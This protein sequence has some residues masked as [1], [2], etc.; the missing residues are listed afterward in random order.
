[1]IKQIDILNFKSL[2]DFQIPCTNLNLFTGTNGAGKS[3]ALQS[4]LLLRQS[5]LSRYFYDD[6]DTIFLGDEQSLVNLG[7]YKDVFYSKAKKNSC[8]DF[9]IKFLDGKLN[10][11]TVKYSSDNKDLNSIIGKLTTGIKDLKGISLF[12][13]NFQYLAAERISPKEDYPRF[14]SN[15][16]S[17]GK[18]GSFTAHFL[19]KFGNK[20]VQIEAFAT[21][22]EIR[23]LALIDH[24]NF[25]MGRISE[26]IQVQTKENLATNRVELF[27]R[28]I[29]QDGVPG[30]DFKPSNV[31]FG[32]TH[33]LPIVVAILAAKTGDLLVIENPETHLHPAGQ[34]KLAQLFSIAAANNIQLMIETHSDHIVNGIRVAIK[35]Q[36]IDNMAI[37]I[38][39]FSKNSLNDTQ[40]EQIYLD[41][42]GGLSAWPN[43]FFDEWDKL[44]ND[45]L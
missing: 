35:K 17:L 25:W 4:M 1:M 10:F 29:N 44:L 5:Y 41:D 34:S 45:L 16:T 14:K 8:I 3:S 2:S 20:D 30:Q 15:E 21:F 28:Y 27:F 23:S 43:G 12:N 32:I 6:D 19:E 37:T 24:V 36:I 11:Q 9:G 22:A 26:N 31:G 7:T 13:D 18:D 39:Y 33:T 38:N 42:D 40:L